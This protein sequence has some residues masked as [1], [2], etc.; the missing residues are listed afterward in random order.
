MS[1]IRDVAKNAGVSIATVSRVLS[2]D[3]TFKVTDETY[4]KIQEAILA[5]DYQY[6]PKKKKSPNE[7][8]I[9]CLMSYTFSKYN[10]PFF[11]TILSAIQD[12]CTKSN[13]PNPVIFTNSLNGSIDQKTLE[14]LHD[15]DGVLVMEDLS[16]EAQL[17]LKESVSTIICIDS[18]IEGVNSVGYDK[19]EANKQIM[20]Y[21]IS[22]NNRR[23]AYIGGDTV[24]EPF[25]DSVQ[26]TVYRDTLARY[27]IEYDTSILYNCKWDTD[28]C[29]KQVLELI[30]IIDDVDAI[31]AGS[32]TLAGLILNILSEKGIKVPTDVNVFGINDDPNSKHTIP[33]LTTLHLPAEEIGRF[34]S[35]L[36]IRKLEGNF[37]EVVKTNFATH[38][39]ER[40][41]T[42][43]IE[44]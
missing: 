14:R 21:L 43:K 3:E 37:K 40:L 39:V 5:L 4:N 23:I 12:E 42:K 35:K 1:T 7:Y 34:A 25:F 2:Q 26:M 38:V 9:G 22:N 8:S 36:L 16:T 31:I 6:K 13:Y 29:Y 44:S 27:N 30:E 11:S 41:S 18:Q 20:D 17:L 32:D 24:D 15:F 33:P 19:Y 10:D 28:L